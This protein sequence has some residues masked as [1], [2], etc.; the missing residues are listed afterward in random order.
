MTSTTVFTI[1][2]VYCEKLTILDMLV[3]VIL[4]AISYIKNKNY[5]EQ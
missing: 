2:F 3:G 4:I 5:P 1:D